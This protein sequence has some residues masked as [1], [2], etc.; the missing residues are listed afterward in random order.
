MD[1]G[2]V[3]GAAEHAKRYYRHGK[4]HRTKPDDAVWY[5][6]VSILKINL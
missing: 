5:Y 1:Y 3:Q 6:Y 4:L 2:P